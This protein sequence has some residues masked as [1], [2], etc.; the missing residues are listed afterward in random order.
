MPRAV[1]LGELHIFLQ[2]AGDRTGR[3]A[4]CVAGSR[5]PRGTRT[6]GGGIENSL[7]LR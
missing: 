6:V 1:A 4:A 2:H 5:L 3:L 7:S